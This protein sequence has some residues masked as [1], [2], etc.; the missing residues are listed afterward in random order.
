[1]KKRLLVGMSGASGAPIAVELLKQ[2]QKEESVET[3]LIV[4]RGA[5][6]TLQQETEL[7]LEDVKAL[8][9]VAYENDNI[10]ARPAS[11]SF[12]MEIGRAHV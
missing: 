11:G 10:G 6:L 8:A 1:M 7:S 9:D 12:Q 5:E 3:H 2:L 4:T